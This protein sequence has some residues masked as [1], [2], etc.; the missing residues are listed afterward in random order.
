MTRLGV[1]DSYFAV[2]PLRGVRT[3]DYHLR[4][5]SGPRPI[6]EPYRHYIENPSMG[7]VVGVPSSL[8]FSPTIKGGHCSAN[9]FDGGFHSEEWR[10]QECS[11]FDSR[12]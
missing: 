12:G 2:K 4:D 6:S 11:L 7:N 1:N 8:G 9:G 5:A 10:D 3:P